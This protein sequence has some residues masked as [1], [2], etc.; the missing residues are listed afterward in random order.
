MWIVV[1]FIS[2]SS[3]KIKHRLALDVKQ[4]GLGRHNYHGCQGKETKQT[5]LGLE[6]NFIQISFNYIFHRY[7]MIGIRVAK[8]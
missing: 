5:Q 7:A 1:N 6:T 3:T 4:G 2:W 8:G